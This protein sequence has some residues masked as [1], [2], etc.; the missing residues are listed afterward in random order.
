MC[1]TYSIDEESDMADG[2]RVVWCEA[3][4]FERKWKVR[5]CKTCEMLASNVALEE[6][7]K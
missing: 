5:D 3:C 1:G 6:E 4:G 2:I 7:I